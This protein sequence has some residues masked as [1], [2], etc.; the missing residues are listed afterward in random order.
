MKKVSI[1]IPVHNSEMHLKQ[2]INSVINQTYKN[3]EIIIINDASTDN[4]L[5]IIKEYNDDRI[6]L[7]DLK[8]NVGV[9]IARNKGIDKATGD[10]ICFLDSDDFWY[11]NKLELQI[12]FIEENNYAFIYSDYLFY[13][14]DKS[15]KTTKVPTSITYNQALKNT[16]IFTSTVM[17]NMNILSKK[18]IY[19]P[20][21]KL[22]QDSLCWWRILKIVNKAYGQNEVLSIYRVGNKSL[23]SNKFKSVSGTWN[24]Y[25]LEKIN[26]FKR[27]Y[28]FTCCILNAIKRRL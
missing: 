17:L 8:E 1:I 20:D 25:K 18:D 27:I 7:I 12:K 14:N 9:S 5:N 21:I 3:I 26:I 28:Y 16:T 6:I 13:K 22:G 23:S 4:S 2:C 19:M 15:T 10:Y 24:L 11:E